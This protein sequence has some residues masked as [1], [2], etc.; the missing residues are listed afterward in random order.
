MTATVAAR[1]FAAWLGL[2]AFVFSVDAQTPA[3]VLHAGSLLAIPGEKPTSRQTILVS[4]G[5]ILAIRSGFL[6]ADEIGAGPGAQ[7]VDLSNAFVLPG[8]IDLHVHLSTEAAGGEA[9]R[10]VT[11][12]AA[13]LALAARLHARETVEAGFT[14]VLDLGT[15]R[16]AHTEAV[17][18]LRRAI[19]LGIATGPRILIAGS[20]I[21]A[22]GSSRTGRYTS[23]V[24]AAVGI[25]GTCDGAD[26]CAR[27][28]RQQVAE[29]AD[30]INMYNTGS[31]GDLTVVQ[32][33]FTDSEMEAIVSTA[34]ASGLRVIADG[35]TAAGINSAL[36]AGVDIID[37]G[38]WPD[39]QSFRLM[40]RGRVYFEPHMYAFKVAVA[41][42]RSGSTSVE[43]Q[44]ESPIITRLTGVL[45]HPF[46]AQRAFEMNIPLAYGSDTGIVRHGD[47]AGD[48]AE[49]VRIGMS[50]MQAIQVATVNSAAAVGLGHEIGSLEVGKR[51]DIIA[52]DGN[53]LEDV[54]QL[55]HVSFV[56]RD[57]HVLK[58]H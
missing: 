38:P 24:A 43:D 53:P 31:I 35:H 27:A 2:W 1:A 28:V 6:S 54:E 18:A 4:D 48:F 7:T 17:Y 34:H 49:L 44:P 13:D 8:L 21:S 37:T 32:Q 56:M 23:D 50:P 26:D 40:K 10:V 55:R 12:N 58:M 19:D 20:P 39:E 22:T 5:R 15:A 36:R 16:A 11:R 33:A 51:A 47:N 42:M 25:Q 14:T 52:T 29:G 46:S 30:V 45:K 57:G 9:L 3:F 41:E